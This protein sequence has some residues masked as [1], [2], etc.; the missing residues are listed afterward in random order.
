M[1]SL[2]PSCNEMWSYLSALPKSLQ[3]CSLLFSLNLFRPPL[4]LLLFLLSPVCAVDFNFKQDQ[5][6]RGYT[7]R[8]NWSVLS[9]QLPVAKNSSYRGG[10]FTLNSSDVRI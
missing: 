3:I 2:R 10:E 1:F 9:Q 8:E 5:L 6:V 7:V 4:L